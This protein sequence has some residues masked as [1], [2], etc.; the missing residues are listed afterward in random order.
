MKFKKQL[1]IFLFGL[2]FAFT[3]LV[4]A[5]TLGIMFLLDIPLSHAVYFSLA[6]SSVILSFFIFPLLRY[7][8]LTGPFAVDTTFYTW[9]DIQRQEQR[10]EQHARELTVHLWA[11][12]TVAQK[13][14]SFF[15]FIDFITALRL[16]FKAREPLSL[17]YDQPTYP[18][19]IFSHGLK[20]LSAFNRAL[21]QDLASHGYVVVGINHTYGCFTPTLLKSNN[22][23]FD[24]ALALAFEQTSQAGLDAYLE[25]LEEEIETWVTDIQFVATML[26]QLNR[27]ESPFTERLNLDALGVYGHSLGGAAAAEAC[28]RDKRFKAGISLDGSLMKKTTGGFSKPFM[29]IRGSLLDASN[30]HISASL[31]LVYNKA[32][33][34]YR[35]NLTQFCNCLGPYGYCITLDQVGHYAFTDASLLCPLARFCLNFCTG[36]KHTPAVIAL[37]NGYAQAFFDTHLK[38]KDTFLPDLPFNGSFYAHKVTRVTKQI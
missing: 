11:P 37:T 16:Y 14:R 7:P 25:R 35:D 24:P 36:S 38:H 30:T 22:L 3:A 13:H 8:T 2:L 12:I 17:S 31:G 34:T 26:T 28:R 15:Y 23:N 29:F 33:K 20:S 21:L 6:S 27:E 9:H 5:T 1:G 10:G 18:V 19:I 4:G 32:L